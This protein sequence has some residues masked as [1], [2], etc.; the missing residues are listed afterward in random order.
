LLVVP[1]ASLTVLGSLALAILRA[2]LVVLA[3][4]PLVLVGLSLAVLPASPVLAALS[5]VAKPP[6]GRDFKF[7]DQIRSSAASAPRNIAEGFGRFRPAP[8][9]NFVD[10]A[11]GSLI[12]TEDALKDG[13]DRGYFTEADI[14]P[15]QALARRAIVVSR[16]LALYPKKR[17]TQEKLHK[18]R[19][20]SPHQKNEWRSRES[21]ERS[22]ETNDDDAPP[23]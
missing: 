1:T 15:L 17:A 18:K 22:E 10:I 23:L 13:C 14:V 11:I 7:C 6:A 9:A 21:D 20:R 19:E 3:A 16:R 2:S 12:E 5:A 4:S 8:F